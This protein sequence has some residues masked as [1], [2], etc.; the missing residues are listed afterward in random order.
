MSVFPI[1]EMRCLE[2]KRLFVFLLCSCTGPWEISPQGEKL[3]HL[4]ALRLSQWD[5][6]HV[7]RV[8]RPD[9]V[10]SRHSVLWVSQTHSFSLH[11]LTQ[12][13]FPPSVMPLPCVRKE[14]PNLVAFHRLSHVPL[15]VKSRCD[16]WLCCRSNAALCLYS[17]VNVTYLI[18]ASDRDMG[19]RHRARA[20]A[21]QIMKVQIIPA[22]KCR[23]P[24]IKQFHV[25]LHVQMMLTSFSF[26]HMHIN[27]EL[28]KRASKGFNISSL[29]STGLQDQV[30]S[31]S[32]GSAP[33]AQAPF[34]HQE[35]KHFLLKCM[36]VL[37]TLQMNKSGENQKSCCMVFNE[38]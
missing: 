33:P 24:A 34:H 22:N 32:Q 26:Y 10:W 6:Q 20:H 31:S 16:M 9:H 25:S 4:A 12:R 1:S 23:R 15:K 30:P 2:S 19:A 38:G 35:T 18:C 14:K 29:D 21:I 36:F 28:F 17:I 27:C 11:T 8:Q 7:P 5:P 3:R 13:S 37:F